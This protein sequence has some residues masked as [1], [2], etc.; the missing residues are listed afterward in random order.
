MRATCHAH[1]S[2]FEN[3]TEF[4]YAIKMVTKKNA[5]EGVETRLN[6][7]SVCYHSVQDILSFGSYL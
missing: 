1:S 4:I 7:V 3:M 6:T 2:S 5:I